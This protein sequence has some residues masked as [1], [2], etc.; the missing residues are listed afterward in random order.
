MTELQ[1]LLQER[2]DD[3]PLI[4]GLA[5]QL[6]LADTIN[7]HIGSHGLQQ[8]L[9]NGQ[10]A[11]GWLAH[12]L[13]Q[14]SHCKSAVEPWANSRSHTLEQLLGAPIRQVEFSDDRLGGVLRRFSDDKTW[15]AL[16]E[17]L[18]QK[19][20]QTYELPLEGVRL[21]S[22]TSYGYHQINED[23]LMQYGV[24]KDHRPDLPQLKLMAATMESSGHMIASDIKPGQRA[25]D[26]LYTPLIERVRNMVKKTGLLYTGD[27]KMAALA[28]RGQLVY[29][30]DFYLVPLPIA[31]KTRDEFENWVDA[32]VDGEQATTLIWRGKQVLAA[33]YEF[34]RLL[35]TK[36]DDQDIEW[37][38]RVQLVRSLSLAKRQSL[39]LD[40]KINKAI[41]AIKSLTPEPGRG[42]RQ[43]RDKR[44]LRA[45][46][47]A[48]MK[49]YK[50]NGLLDVDWKK[51]TTKTTRYKGRGRG[52]A[53]RTTK[54]TTKIR[55]EI[56]DV[57]RNEGAID[58]RRH[59]F[60]W[61]AQAT[62]ATTK[63]LSFSQATLHYRQGFSIERG[64][65]L[66][67]DLPLGLSP[68]FVWK[69]DQIKG[70]T[71]LLTIALRLMTLIETVVQR[72]QKND[73]EPLKGLYEGQ[74]KRTTERPTA[75]RILNAFNKANISMTCIKV[76]IQRHWHLTPLSET[77]KKILKYLK[78]PLPHIQSSFLIHHSPKNLC[79][80][81]VMIRQ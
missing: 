48:E 64:F 9:N 51:Y 3:V 62:N 21:D 75:K 69:D 49:T 6:G 32:I 29:H 47:D 27:C 31:N 22:T 16:E 50:V 14:A 59:R 2:L 71:R 70:L 55:Y 28:T 76:G 25:D 54:T 17:E 18:W 53:N 40:K 12:I 60:G 36:I 26:R 52:N 63:R 78:I 37:I 43:I 45:A 61:R 80:T 46:I 4:V 58:A 57:K 15:E 24:S 42:K 66:V 30:K 65:H 77:H 1:T 41:D 35:N 5:N 33:G 19:T 74:P 73:D 79:E 23:G 7:R 38:E 44:K 81:R 11:V 8:G 56:T 39:E 20:I 13:S 67:K 34:K 68:L 10:L 72:E